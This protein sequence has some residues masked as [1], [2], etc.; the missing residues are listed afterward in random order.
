[1]SLL[2]A[3]ENVQPFLDRYLLAVQPLW[4][5]SGVLYKRHVFAMWPQ[6]GGLESLG[7]RSP[8]VAGRYAALYMSMAAMAAIWTGQRDLEM[9][10]FPEGRSSQM[11]TLTLSC[12]QP[13]L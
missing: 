3:N 2:E 7:G 6:S 13:K 8:A 11:I 1:V 12:R 9:A 10:N 4:D 5:F